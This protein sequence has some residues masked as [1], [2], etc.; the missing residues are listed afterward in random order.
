MESLLFSEGHYSTITS[1]HYRKVN[2]GI[3]WDSHI[4]WLVQQFEGDY[5]RFQGLPE[6]DGTILRFSG[7]TA[8]GA[9]TD[10]GDN[11]LGVD[12]YRHPLGALTPGQ[13]A[14]S[15]CLDIGSIIGT[16]IPP[17]PP[18]YSY[19]NLL[20]QLKTYQ[21]CLS[22]YDA[23]A[24][25]EAPASYEEAKTLYN[26]QK[27]SPRFPQIH[28]VEYVVADKWAVTPER[29]QVSAD[30][31]DLLREKGKGVYQLVFWGSVDGEP[32]AIADY[33]LF[34]EVKAPSGYSRR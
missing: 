30:I 13:V 11:G 27:S 1:E 34:H 21:G 14:R 8:N 22:P 31:G 12:I 23:S 5:V 26:R 9:K 7:Q 32:Q 33:W 28:S 25:S 3:A 24:D 10:M 4:I 2:L 6:L 19:D 17:A 18:G 20:P 29:F 15:Y 16:I